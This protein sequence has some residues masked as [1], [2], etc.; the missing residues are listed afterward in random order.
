MHLA[1]AD[2]KAF[3]D[4]VQVTDGKS[5]EMIGTSRPLGT[6]TSTTSDYNEI[7]DPYPSSD[8]EIPER[9]NIYNTMSDSTLQ[10]AI[11]SSYEEPVPTPRVRICNLCIVYNTKCMIL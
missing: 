3:D 10:W 11:A 1:T 4:S 6:F 5:Y 2:E 9:R 7:D 8:Q